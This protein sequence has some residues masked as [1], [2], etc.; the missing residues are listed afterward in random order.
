VIDD[1]QAPTSGKQISTN[2]SQLT[3][4]SWLPDVRLRQKSSPSIS[5]A[6]LIAAVPPDLLLN[7]FAV[8]KEVQEW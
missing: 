2:S 6:L 7:I 3:E 5:P 4:S 1:S 8:R